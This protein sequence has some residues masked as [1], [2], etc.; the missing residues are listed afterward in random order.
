MNYCVHC[1]VVP[2]IRFPE[3]S[4]TV[5]FTTPSQISIGCSAIGIPQ[6][7]VEWRFADTGVIV[8]NGAKYSLKVEVDRDSSKAVFEVISNL[9]IN[10][11]ITNDTR[12]Y[13]CSV[14]SLE[15]TTPVETTINVIVEGLIL[16]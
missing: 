16:F 12:P 6:P 7:I 8:T 13:I 2:R 3:R 9:I 15:F 5:N 4:F 10:N 11:P 14:R 1:T